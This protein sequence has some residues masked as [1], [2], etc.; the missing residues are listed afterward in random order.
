RRP[1]LFRPHAAAHG[2]PVHAPQFAGGAEATAAAGGGGD[3]RGADGVGGRAWDAA[4][5]DAS[6]AAADGRDGAGAGRR[7]GGGVPGDEEQ[8]SKK[9]RVIIRASGVA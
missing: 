5:V 1:P 2:H 8:V 9:E 6:S 4:V 3:A 7:G